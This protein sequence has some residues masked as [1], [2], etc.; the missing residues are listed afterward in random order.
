MGRSHSLNQGD[1]HHFTRNEREKAG[2]GTAK[3]RLGKD[4]QLPFGY[5]ALCLQNSKDAMATPSGHVYC[6]ECILA[7][8]LAKKQDLR[9][10]QEAY[11][12]QQKAKMEDFKAE[13][14]EASSDVLT[15]FVESQALTSKD[16]TGTTGSNKGKKRL[17]EG[18]IPEKYPMQSRDELKERLKTTSWWLPNF[19]P[20]NGPDDIAEPEPRPRSPISSEFLRAKDLIPLNFARDDA[21]AKG[22]Q[23]DA[24]IV[25]AVTQKELRTQ[26]IA[27]IKKSGQVMLYDALEKFAT[28][29]M[30]C[31]VTGVK[32]KKKD[33]LPLVTGGSSFSAS[34]QVEA[35]KY[36]PTMT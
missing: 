27:V 35:K 23:G 34:G 7:Y 29:S 30:T 10:Q 21:N 16:G 31:P 33:I 1:H 5:C 26:K 24:N 9:R 36:N 4:S 32:F 11:D 13:A 14:E 2:Y 8:L 17:R 20:D 28:P 22:S 25:C 18:E 19:T 12:A 6:R 15:L 3:V